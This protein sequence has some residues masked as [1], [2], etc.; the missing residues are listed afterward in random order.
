M[1][2]LFVLNFVVDKKFSWFMHTND[3]KILITVILWISLHYWLHHCSIGR[4]VLPFTASPGTPTT[5]PPW[6]NSALI[7]M[8]TWS[9]IPLRESRP[10]TTRAGREGSGMASASWPCC[11]SF[12]WAWPSWHSPSIS[13][14][15]W[16]IL[17]A[18]SLSHS[19]QSLPNQWV[20]TWDIIRYII[21][22][23]RGSGVSFFVDIL[24]F[25][26][27]LYG[28]LQIILCQYELKR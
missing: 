21:R 5:T 25:T 10:S 14:A 13:T 28:T 7:T 19:L 22:S 15:T 16:R 8:A 2:K 27:E 17:T 24:A 4:D 3:K 26:S 18:P 20:C 6:R 11:P 23:T 9:P 1:I 12:Q